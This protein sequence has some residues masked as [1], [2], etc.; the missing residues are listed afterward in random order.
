[1][2]KFLAELIGC[3]VESLQGQ[4]VG[5]ICLVDGALVPTCNWRHRRGGLAPMS[6]LYWPTSLR[7][8]LG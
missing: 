3:P 4:V 7:T 1:M 8:T 2:A 6:G 5:K